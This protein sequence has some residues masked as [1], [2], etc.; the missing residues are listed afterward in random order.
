MCQIKRVWQQ[1]S[2]NPESPQWM[3]LGQAKILEPWNVTQVEFHSISRVSTEIQMFRPS[4]IVFPG[5]LAARWVRSKVA[6]LEY[7]MLTSQSAAN[8]TV[9]QHN[10]C[11]LQYF[12]NLTFNDVFKQTFLQA[13]HTNTMG[14][15]RMLNTTNYQRIAN[16]HH[17]EILPDSSKIGCYKNDKNSSYCWV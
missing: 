7:G 10:T 9:S 8:P 5:V 6:G 3:G 1:S 2:L 14:T 11:P 16:Q 15:W 13:W 17:S 4:C 12:L